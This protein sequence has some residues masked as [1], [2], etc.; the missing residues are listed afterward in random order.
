MGMGFTNS[1]K[2]KANM[3]ILVTN[4]TGKI[5]R[6]IVRELLAPEFSVRVIVRD[7][8]RLPHEIREEVEVVRGSTDDA[9]TLRRALDGV[10]AL[11]WCVPTSRRLAKGLHTALVP[12][13]ACTR[14]RTS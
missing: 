4:P 12:S 8:A 13:Q 11:F 1:M 6:E 14:W 9:Q 3:K 5:G 10:E 7:P 2:E